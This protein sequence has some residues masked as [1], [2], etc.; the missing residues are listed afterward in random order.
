MVYLFYRVLEFLSHAG[1][2]APKKKV[3]DLIISATA[4]IRLHQKI[5]FPV[6]RRGVIFPKLEFF[7][8][9]IPVL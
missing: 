5:V 2:H 8:S 4:M 7:G 1:Q 3:V 6:G 9:I